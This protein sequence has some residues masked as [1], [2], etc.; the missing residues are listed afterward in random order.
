M[1]IKTTA[2]YARRSERGIASWAAAVSG[3]NSAQDRSEYKVTYNI[4]LPL[5]IVTWPGNEDACAHFPSRRTAYAARAAYRA[6]STAKVIS[7][8][9][10]R[11]SIRR[12]QQPSRDAMWLPRSAGTFE[13]EIRFMETHAIHISVR[14][15]TTRNITCD[16]YARLVPN[17]RI[18]L[19]RNN[20]QYYT[21][22]LSFPISQ[23]V[24]RWFLDKFFSR[25]MKF[26]VSKNL[27]IAPRH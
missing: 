19:A 18:F 16:N 12:V 8:L 21:L 20:V 10:I 5:V 2:H 23:N 13:K 22:P 25:I 1:Q 11:K 6:R 14:D 7:R 4:Y 3:L 27:D 15:L 9:G 26:R 17:K 24:F